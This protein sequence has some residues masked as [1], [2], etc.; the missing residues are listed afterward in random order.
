VC[1]YAVPFFALIRSAISRFRA[2]FGSKFCGSQAC[3]T[4]RVSFMRSAERHKRLAAVGYAHI[5]RWS[6]V[7]TGSPKPPKRSLAAIRA[8]AASRMGDWNR[9]GQEKKIC[10]RS[11][12]K[13]DLR[14][15]TGRAR[16]G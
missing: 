10:A 13:V 7:V 6:G 3:T 12:F 16:S 14:P 9:N 8:D 11:S 2:R 1:P 5:Y 15:A 4:S